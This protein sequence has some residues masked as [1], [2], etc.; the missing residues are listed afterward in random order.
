MK[1]SEK[2]HIGVFGRR[3]EK[4]IVIKTTVSKNSKTN[5]HLSLFPFNFLL[6]PPSTA[7]RCITLLCASVR[8][9]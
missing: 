1:E 5:G 6:F 7:Q 9:N 3:K 8:A 2:G 4:N